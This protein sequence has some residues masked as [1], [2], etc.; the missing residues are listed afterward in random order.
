MLAVT[1]GCSAVPSVFCADAPT[2]RG[3]AAAFIIRSILGESFTYNQTPVFSDVPSTHPQ[4]AYIQK[5]KE[6]NY[7]NGCALA[8]ARYCPEDPVLR[9]QMAVFLTKARFVSYNPS[10][11]AYFADVPGPGTAT[12]NPNFQFIQQ[13]RGERHHR[14]L[15]RQS[16]PVLPERY[17]QPGPDGGVPDSSFLHE[18]TVA[19]SGA[20]RRNPAPPFNPTPSQL[21]NQ[22]HV[23][24]PKGFSRRHRRGIVDGARI[25][26]GQRGE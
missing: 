6:L 21:Y 10:P 2:T 4:F 3:Q 5:M 20:Q 17:G 15:Q 18:L 11:A 26:A 9:E 23:L 22:S 19:T 8:P 24:H 7:T 16:A 13:L 1:R 14:G 12:A 25:L